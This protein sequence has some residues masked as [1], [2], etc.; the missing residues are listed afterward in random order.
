MIKKINNLDDIIEFSDKFIADDPFIN[1]YGYYRGGI[2]IA[3]IV[4]SIQYDRAE[5]NYVWTSIEYRNKGYASLLMK[6][7]LELCGNLINITLEV[8]V[9][10]TSAINL[11]ILFGFKEVA[12][13]KHYYN[14][15]FKCWF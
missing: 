15:D 2:L 9:E 6:K 4:F 10:N 5:L 8:D 3:F 1:A 11:Y 14:N 12:I 7:M 13:R